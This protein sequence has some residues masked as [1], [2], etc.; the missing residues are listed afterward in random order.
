MKI[1][2]LRILKIGGAL[3]TDKS[4]GVFDRAKEDVIEKIAKEI[5]TNPEKLI[6]IHGVGS[7]GHPYVEKYNLKQDRRN[8]RGVAETHLACERLC[9]IV[10]KALA[11]SGLN[12]A[13]IHPFS[14]F[15]L[16]DSLEFDAGF[17]ADLVNDGFIPVIHGDMVRSHDGY[18]VLSGDKIAVELARVFKAEKIGFASD[19]AIVAGGKIV[20]E[21]TAANVDSV[22]AEL[23]SETSKSD[24]TG[25][26]R[27]KV[28]AI[29]EVARASEV[30]IFSGLE[31]GNVAKFLAGEHVGTKIRL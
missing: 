8:V 25:G 13:P 29:L 11:E 12:P 6:L 16:T 30:F 18:E 19:T 24:V 26:M 4:R 23:N 10:C 22:L 28:I 3:I 5:A 17:I 31:P 9:C 21:V 14:S 15:R 7:F 27:G 20:E 2:G 1:D